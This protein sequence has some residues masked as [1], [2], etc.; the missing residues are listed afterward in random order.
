MGDF[1]EPERVR[2]RPARP[3]PDR[4]LIVLG[5]LGVAIVGDL[6]A[7]RGW[8]RL[9]LETK[10]VVAMT[11]RPHRRRDARP[12]RVRVVEPG[13]ARRA[14]RGP[15]AAQRAVRV[16]RV[17][18]RRDEHDPDRRADRRDPARRDRADVHRRR[19]PARPAAAS[20][21][22]RSRSCWR[23]SSRPCSAARTR[24]RSAGGCPRSIVYRALSV[25]L[26]SVA[27]VFGCT[28]L[29]EVTTGG[30]T[31]SRSRSRRCPRS[32]RSAHSTGITPALPDTSLLVLIVAM[33][34]GRLGPLTLVLALAARARPVRVP[35]RRRDDPHR[36]IPAHEGA[37]MKTS[38]LVIG[39]GRFG[40]GRGPRADGARPRGARGRPER[41]DRQRDRART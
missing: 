4:V 23:R 36:L 41:G 9:A 18:V 32:A 38:V 28:L 25:A 37:R 29:L 13:D 34:V 7:K 40:V 31:S 33:F 35:A 12:A 26:L 6:L 17:P 21:S 11:V 27:L 5:G 10:L 20:S 19:P 8:V 3:R 15:A 2:E 24:R 16:D 22:R 30:R 39:L 1:R 14:A